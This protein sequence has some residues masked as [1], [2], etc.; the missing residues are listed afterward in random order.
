MEAALLQAVVPVGGGDGDDERLSGD[1][2]MRADTVVF[3][4]Y[5][6]TNVDGVEHTCTVSTEYYKI[7]HELSCH[8]NFVHLFTW[9]HRCMLAGTFYIL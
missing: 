1:E 6:L 9:H 3:P 4:S 2:A 5:S 8:M 7:T